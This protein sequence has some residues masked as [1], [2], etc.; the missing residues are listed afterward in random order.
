[1]SAARTQHRA[2]GEYPSHRAIA[3]GIA[4]SAGRSGFPNLKKNGQKNTAPL[5]IG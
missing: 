1:M 5:C 3:N 4:P 2:R